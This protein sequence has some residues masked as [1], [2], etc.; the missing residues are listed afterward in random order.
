MSSRGM[1]GAFD[2]GGGVVGL[3]V[4]VDLL[5]AFLAFVS[6]AAVG[7]AVSCSAGFAIFLAEVLTVFTEVVSTLVAADSLVFFAGIG[8]HL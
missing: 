8:T 2:A 5:A 7:L 6:R 4:A 1:C 3:E